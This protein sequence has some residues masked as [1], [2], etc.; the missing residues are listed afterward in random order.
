ML[1]ESA[2]LNMR[3]WLHSMPIGAS[4]EFTELVLLLAEVGGAL[5]CSE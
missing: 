1:A 5:T 3:P 2:A 4:R